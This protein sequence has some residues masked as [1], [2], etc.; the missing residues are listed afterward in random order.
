MNSSDLPQVKRE[1]RPTLKTIA[2]ISGLAMTTVS[3][4][5]GDAPDISRD[6]KERVRKIADQIGYVP[7]RAGVRLRTGKTNVISLVLATEQGT[8]NMT[9]DLISAIA[10]GL[11]GTR[12]H[13]VMIPEPKDQDP[14][15]AIR[16]IVETRSADA[17]IFNQVTPDDPRVTYLRQKGFPFVTHGRS[18]WAADHSYYD[19]DNIAFGRI[20]VERLAARGRKQILLL[21]PPTA[22]SYARDIIKGATMAAQGLDL[23]LKVADSISSD[24]V[25]DELIVGIRDYLS[26]KP[27][28]DAVICASPNSAMIA[29]KAIEDA[30]YVIG[31][32][33]DIFAKETFPFLDIFRAGILSVHEDVQKAGSFL[34][35][36]AIHEITQR[37]GSHM[38]EV[39]LP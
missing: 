38:Q 10:D 5:L 6:T 19:Y 39:E 2:R 17:V 34:A 1:E 20:A 15:R 21:A 27:T 8:L 18:K 7:N 14:L 26:K 32:Q 31:E 28:L 3:R 25:K 33:F 29:T 37:D 13:L 30:G 22:Q 9:S 12:Y 16:N 11:E 35:K 4:A 36:A 24:S 23:S